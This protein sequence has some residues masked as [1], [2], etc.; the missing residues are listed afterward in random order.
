[1]RKVARVHKADMAVGWGR[2][3][4]GATASKGP[5]G[6]GGE[7]GRRRRVVEKRGGLTTLG[8]VRVCGDLKKGN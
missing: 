4:L 7:R 3:S 8:L 6:R 2:V 1:M 5:C